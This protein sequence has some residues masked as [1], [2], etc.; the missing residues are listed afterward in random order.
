[1]PTPLPMRL[2]PL[3]KGWE[4]ARDSMM[5]AK[6]VNGAA[7]VDTCSEMLRKILLE[8]LQEVK[9]FKARHPD[10]KIR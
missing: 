2:S 8:Y 5:K 4:L 3:I 9:A 7:A 10:L 6:D 1:M